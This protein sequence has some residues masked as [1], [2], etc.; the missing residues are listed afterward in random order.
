MSGPSAETKNNS[1]EQLPKPFSKTCRLVHNEQPNVPL[2]SD[3]GLHTVSHL[4][5]LHNVRGVLL[6]VDLLLSLEQRVLAMCTAADPVI[7]LLVQD[8][9]HTAHTADAAAAGAMH[10][11]G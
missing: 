1:K 11:V 3:P 5:E 8:R 9:A 2:E 7:I 4:I 6:L 10:A